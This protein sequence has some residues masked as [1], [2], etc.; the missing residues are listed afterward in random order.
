MSDPD[1]DTFPLA[2]KGRKYQDFAVG[3]KLP[4]HWGRTIT[5]G[6]NATF[7]TATCAWVPLY[8]NAEYARAHGHP[9]A[10]VNPMLVLCTV[11]G[12]SVEDLS[13]AGG[14]FLGIDDCVFHL[15][16]Y[17]GD[18][19]TARSEVVDRRLSSN[20]PGAG[21][22]TWH[23]EGHNQRGELV[24]ELR[25]TNLVALRDPIEGSAA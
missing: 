9:D 18:T 5:G 11:V 20:R 14:P 21:I 16:V 10:V 23:T 19:L 8:L 3:Q 4:H 1:F 25:R 7:S 13:E 17:P 6:D 15:P 22:V 2:V 24:V 12:I